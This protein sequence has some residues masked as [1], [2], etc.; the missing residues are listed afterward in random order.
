MLCP[1]FSASRCS[2]LSLF[3]QVW[4]S[5]GTLP[6]I[7]SEPGQHMVVYHILND[8]IDVSVSTLE[9]SSTSKELDAGAMVRSLDD[10]LLDMKNLVEQTARVEQ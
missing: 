5:S 9:V 6:C 10:A 7:G 3:V 4:S 8:H 1:G 2:L